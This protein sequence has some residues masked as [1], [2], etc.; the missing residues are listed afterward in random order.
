MGSLGCTHP[1]VQAWVSGCQL[2]MNPI[3]Q[4]ALLAPLTRPC[5]EALEEWVLIIF[6]GMNTNDG[7]ALEP[8]K[9]KKSG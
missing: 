5:L 4:E 6:W 1:E 2:V 3:I 8:N 9:K 7:E